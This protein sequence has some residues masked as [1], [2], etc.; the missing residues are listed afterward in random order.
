[1]IYLLIF[2]AVVSS[3]AEVCN[4]VEISEVE[5]EVLALPSCTHSPLSS[6]PSE[7]LA[8]YASF[9]V[10]LPALGLK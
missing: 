2:V 9:V 5:N 10:P 6:A 7:F 3:V 4:L 1:L 8:L